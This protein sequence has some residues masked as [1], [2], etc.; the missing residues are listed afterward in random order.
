[1]NK[2]WVCQRCGKHFNPLQDN[3]EFSFICP[4]CGS[5]MTTPNSNTV[6]RTPEN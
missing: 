1:M 3:G 6:K 5:E 2:E 4:E